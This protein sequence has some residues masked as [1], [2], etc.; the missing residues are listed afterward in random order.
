M[1]DDNK[2]VAFLPRDQRDPRELHAKNIITGRNTSN[3]I[4]SQK[5]DLGCVADALRMRRGCVADVSTDKLSCQTRDP[6]STDLGSLS[7]WLFNSVS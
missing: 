2:S 3:E 7:Q 4:A 5:T 6:T 1:G